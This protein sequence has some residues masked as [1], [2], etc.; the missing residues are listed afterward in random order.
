MPAPEQPM[1]L[2]VEASD[3]TSPDGLS[4]T[5]HVRFLVEMVISYNDGVNIHAAIVRGLSIA[6]LWLWVTVYIT[7]RH[8]CRLC[9]IRDIGV[10]PISAVLH[11]DRQ[12]KTNANFSSG[13]HHAGWH[14]F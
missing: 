6:E 13:R 7:N 4:R 8:L 9:R 10:W 12:L 14:E 2:L 3:S 5:G 1:I 11:E